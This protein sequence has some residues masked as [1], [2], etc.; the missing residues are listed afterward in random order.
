M[1]IFSRRFSVIAGDDQDI[2]PV[3]IPLV[4]LQ[5]V[6][7]LIQFRIRETALRVL[8]FGITRAKQTPQPGQH[9]GT[10]RRPRGQGNH[11]CFAGWHPLE[12]F[13]V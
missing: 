7:A 3:E 9:D 6:S 12:I 1:F 5:L 8:A 2:S 13:N 4:D 11:R 10:Y